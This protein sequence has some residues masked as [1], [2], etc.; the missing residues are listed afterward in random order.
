M[1]RQYTQRAFIGGNIA[2][3]DDI[4]EELSVAAAEAN[5]QLDQNNMRLKSGRMAGMV[6]RTPQ[7]GGENG[8]V[9]ETTRVVMGGAYGWFYQN[10]P[11]SGNASSAPLFTSVP[12]A[13]GFTNADSSNNLSTFAKPLPTTT[14]GYVPRTLS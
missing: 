14:L 6:E 8:G 3:T 9:N 4:N 1:P 5:G 13:Q 7:V 12:F 11:F 2:K 10:P